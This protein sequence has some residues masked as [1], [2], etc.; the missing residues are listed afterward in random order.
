[1]ISTAQILAS[2]IVASVAIWF[3]PDLFDVP[4]LSEFSFLGQLGL[5]VLGLSVLELA[6]RRIL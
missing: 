6:F 2:F 1:M 4:G 5:V 3:G